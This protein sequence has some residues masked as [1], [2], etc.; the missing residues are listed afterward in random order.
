MINENCMVLKEDKA[1]FFHH[2]VAKLPYLC[3]HTRQDIQTAVAFFCTRV[4]RPDEDDYKKLVRAM[5][6]LCGSKHITLIIEANEHLNWWMDSSYTVHPDIHSHSSVYMTLGKGATYSGSFK[7]K[8]NMKSSM[9]AELV[10]TDDAMG[11][12]L[13]TGISWQPKD[14]MYQQQLCTRTTRVPSC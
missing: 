4:K 1:Q 10:A 14:I 8:L 11:Q 7:Q 12:I 9:E 13:W 5:Q 2:L 3:R 6:Y